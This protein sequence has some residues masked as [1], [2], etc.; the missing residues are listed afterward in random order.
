MEA[1]AYLL[2]YSLKMYRFKA[3]G[4]EL[5]PYPLRLGNISKNFTINNMKKTGLKG[6][7]HVLFFY[8]NI[9]DTNNV[10][11]IHKY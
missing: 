9:I 10:L 6:Y 8:C 5:K 2:M 1:A 7:V 3:I 11:D 4:S